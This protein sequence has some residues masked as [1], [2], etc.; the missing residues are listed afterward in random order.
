MNVHLYKKKLFFFVVGFFFVLIGNP[1]R[2]LHHTEQS[3]FRVFRPTTQDLLQRTV[4]TNMT[5][6][7][8]GPEDATRRPVANVQG[9]SQRLQPMEFSRRNQEID[10][11]G[12]RMKK[13]RHLLP[14]LFSSSPT[15]R[16]MDKS[17]S[18][19]TSFHLPEIVQL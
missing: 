4:L 8:T 16:P 11:E 9:L 3:C 1:K 5:I 14:Q 6:P 10:N 7:P 12:R 15:K 13:Q 17:D 19:A 18:K 2:K